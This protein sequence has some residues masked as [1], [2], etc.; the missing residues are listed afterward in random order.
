MGEIYFL[1]FY[2]GKTY[3]IYCIHEYHSLLDH[4]MLFAFFLGKYK[5]IVKQLLT[6]AK[7]FKKSLGGIFQ[8]ETCFSKSRISKITKRIFMIWHES[9]LSNEHWTMSKLK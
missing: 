2:G 4:S 5:I 6:C 1:K 8:D 7:S 9:V 3:L